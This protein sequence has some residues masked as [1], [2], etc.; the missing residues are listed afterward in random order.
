M[1]SYVHGT[2]RLWKGPLLIPRYSFVMLVES[3]MSVVFYFIYRSSSLE[4]LDEEG[5]SVAELEMMVD[6]KSDEVR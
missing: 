5:G 3:M 2:S 4:I 1:L 6:G